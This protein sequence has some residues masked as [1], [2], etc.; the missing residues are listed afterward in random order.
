MKNVVSL[1]IAQMTKTSGQGEIPWIP[2]D[3][4]ASDVKRLT[5]DDDVPRMDDLVVWGAK[6]GPQ[7]HKM[8]AAMGQS[9][10]PETFAQ[11]FG[12]YRLGVLINSVAPFVGNSLEPVTQAAMLHR[13]DEHMPGVSQLLLC[14]REERMDDAQLW[15][16]EHKSMQFWEAKYKALFAGTNQG[17]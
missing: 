6:A 9:Q 11:L 10:M 12:M 8:L 4:D 16:Q 15:H 17:T 7:I 3:F 5:Q 13:A 2:T 14:L 1:K